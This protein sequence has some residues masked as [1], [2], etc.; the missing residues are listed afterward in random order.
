MMSCYERTIYPKTYV[1]RLEIEDTQNIDKSKGN[2]VIRLL[3][4][5]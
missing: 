5:L 2:E 3:W 4:G 1:N